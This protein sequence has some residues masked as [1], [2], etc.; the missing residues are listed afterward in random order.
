VLKVLFIVFGPWQENFL[1][2]WRSTFGITTDQVLT[3]PGHPAGQKWN[4][5][6]HASFDSMLAFVDHRRPLKPATDSS[7]AE[8]PLL[9]GG[10][11]QRSLASRPGSARLQ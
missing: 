10:L 5:R 8:K 11:R 4:S 2:G 1:G 3:P 9:T 6:C 7:L